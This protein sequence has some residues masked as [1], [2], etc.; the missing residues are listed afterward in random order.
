MYLIV[1]ANT[2]QI[3]T[4][5]VIR[6]QLHAIYIYNYIIFNWNS[7]TQQVQYSNTNAKTYLNPT[8]FQELVVIGSCPRLLLKTGYWD[9]WLQWIIVYSGLFPTR[10]FC[11][12]T[13]GWWIL[14]TCKK[15]IVSHLNNLY[16]IVVLHFVANLRGRIGVKTYC[17]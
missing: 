9:T 1:F 17:V 10:L 15:T 2:F 4:N 13:T 7:N 8:L 11:T 3:Q 12:C 5:N 6:I 14:L 16:F